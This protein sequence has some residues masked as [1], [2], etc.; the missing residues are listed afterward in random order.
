ME[1]YGSKNMLILHMSF[2]IFLHCMNSYRTQLSQPA[3][4]T[5]DHLIISLCSRMSGCKPKHGQ[6]E[7]QALLN[8]ALQHQTRADLSP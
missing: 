8:A 5:A 6:C 7:I 1:D 4:D 2:G 3:E